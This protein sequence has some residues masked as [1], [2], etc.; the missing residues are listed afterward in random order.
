MVN[1]TGTTE[2]GVAVALYRQ[3][4]PSTAIAQTTADASGNFAFD[5]ITL[6]AGSQAFIVVA[7]DVAGNTSKLTQTI[8]TTASD[9]SPP[10]ITAALADDTDITS[11][12]GITSDPTITGRRG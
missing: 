11:G 6:A 8:T 9:T 3:W 1:L 4:D 12:G 5:G 7:T 10:V 2:A